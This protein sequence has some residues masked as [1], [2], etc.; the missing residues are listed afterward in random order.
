MPIYE[1]EC[2][3][4]GRRRE[5]LHKTIPV[6]DTNICDKCNGIMKRVMSAVNH[7]IDGYSYKNLYGLKGNKN[8][9]EDKTKPKKDIK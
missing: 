1:Y 9:K 7:T 2:K 5:I 6:T 8:G 3:D 4:C